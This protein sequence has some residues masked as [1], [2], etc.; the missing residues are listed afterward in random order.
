MNTEDNYRIKIEE[1]KEVTDP[2]CVP[3]KHKTF[4]LQKKCQPST[5]LEKLLLK[6]EW[7]FKSKHETF[8]EAIIAMR[9]LHN[10]ENPTI[11]YYYKSNLL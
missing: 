10:K 11:K 5:L 2:W 8:D 7:L 3:T 6:D 1:W 9:N 4:I